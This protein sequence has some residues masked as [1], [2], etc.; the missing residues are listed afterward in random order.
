VFTGNTDWK[1][2]HC[3]YRSSHKIKETDRNSIM[4]IRVWLFL[5]TASKKVST[6]EW[7]E[8]LRSVTM[9]SQKMYVQATRINLLVYLTFQ[10]QVFTTCTDRFN[11][12]SSKFFPQSVFCRRFSYWRLL[13][14]YVAIQNCFS[15]VSHC[16]LCEVKTEYLC[17][18]WLMLNFTRPWHGLGGL[19]PASY[20]GGQ[21]YISGQST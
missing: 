21:D 14:S 6:K 3:S 7:R 2:K 8:L 15:I 1:I 13:L 18:C 4:K 20:C 9:H 11:I 5:T 10:N 17:M 19:L 12:K 16:V